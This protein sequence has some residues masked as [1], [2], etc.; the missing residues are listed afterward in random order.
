MNNWKYYLPYVLMAITFIAWCF[1]VPELF[2]SE[3]PFWVSIIV[4]ALGFCG[5]VL[6]FKFVDKHNKM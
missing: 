2:N 3:L 5:W 4:T 6:L 1:V